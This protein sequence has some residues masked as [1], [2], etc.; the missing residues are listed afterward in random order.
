V[1]AAC[2]IG[3]GDALA[4]RAGP[5]AAVVVDAGPDPSVVDGCLRGLGVERVPLL[6]LTHFHADHIDG[7]SGVLRG[8]AVG[9]VDVTRL[10]DPPDG[11]S[12]VEAQAAAAGLAT[13]L[14]PY[15]VTRTVG[16]ATL[17][18]LWPTPDS[19]TEGPGDGSTANDASVVLLVEVHGVRLLLTG[20]VETTSQAALA[21]ALPGLHV[22]VLKVPHHGSRYQ[23]HEWLASLG[24]RFAVVSVG[25]DNDYGHPA[26]ETIDA[27][28]AAGTEVL[29][30]DRD[31]DVVVAVRDGRLFAA[32]RQ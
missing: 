9:E 27:L 13:D 20:D 19:P 10:A 28:K 11:A 5:H 14:A 17:Q 29:R 23:D 1:F 8:R 24:A 4:V 26:A 3:Q 22:D 18:V 21:R 15:G 7:L 2:D 6:V 12:V 31:G 16:E 32:T 25:A 30:T